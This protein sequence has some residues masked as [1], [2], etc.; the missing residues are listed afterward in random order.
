[1]TNN[2]ASTPAL[3]QTEPIIIINGLEY[4][5]LYKAD[6]FA[7]LAAKLLE[8]R[9]LRI[10]ASRAPK[11]APRTDCPSCGGQGWLDGIFCFTCGYSPE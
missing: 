10:A 8:E 4:P 9:E 3:P 6:V 2:T 7:H 11:P 1:M 5:G